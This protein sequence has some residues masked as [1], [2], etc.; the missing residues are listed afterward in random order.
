MK[1]VFAVLREREI[2]LV[3]VREEVEALRFVIPLLAEEGAPARAIANVSASSP[4]PN[5]KWPLEVRASAP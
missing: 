4:R 1:D 5:N 3:R 2:D